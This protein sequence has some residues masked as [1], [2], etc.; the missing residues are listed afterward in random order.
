MPE[1]TADNQIGFD[2]QHRYHEL[3]RAVEAV[4]ADPER[5]R[6]P[7]WTPEQNI[8]YWQGLLQEFHTAHVGE[9]G[10]DARGEYVWM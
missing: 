9:W 3:I 2:A 5:G 4:N 7:E 8:A 10:V 6:P 1:R